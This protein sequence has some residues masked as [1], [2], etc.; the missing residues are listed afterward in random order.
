MFLALARFPSS[1]R[2]DGTSLGSS[3]H[4]DYGELQ[5]EAPRSRTKYGRIC[6]DVARRQRK[7]TQHNQDGSSSRIVPKFRLSKGRDVRPEW[8]HSFSDRDRQSRRSLETYRQNNLPILRIPH[9]RHRPNIKG[10]AKRYRG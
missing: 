5:L 3:L 8:K 9:T 4:V 10:N 1:D 7:R 6:R 2:P